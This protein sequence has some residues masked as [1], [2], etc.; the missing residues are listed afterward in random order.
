MQIKI[1]FVNVTKYNLKLTKPKKIRATKTKKDKSVLKV[2]NQFKLRKRY[3]DVI[4]VSD[5]KFQWDKEPNVS[6]ICSW[7]TN[8]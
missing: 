8:C 7:Q 4:L 5:G 3:D 6:N 2:E 1:S